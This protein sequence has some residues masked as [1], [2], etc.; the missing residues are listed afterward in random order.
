[1]ISIFEGQ[2]FMLMAIS[3]AHLDDPE[4]AT[5]AYDQVAPHH[6]SAMVLGTDDE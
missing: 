4:N 5:A 1:M 2:T 6:N 3:L